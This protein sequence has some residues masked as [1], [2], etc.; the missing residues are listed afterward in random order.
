MVTELARLNIARVAR[1]EPPLR[2]GIGIH[3]GDAVVG[4]IG[5]PRHRLEYTAIGDTVN[6]ASRI[7]GLTKIAGVMLLRVV[8]D[9]CPGRRSVRVA[10]TAADGDQGQ[11]RAH[12][13]LG[14]DGAG[15]CR[16]ESRGLGVAVP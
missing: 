13:G 1:N 15:G 11:E 14:A 12:R 4:D 9:P 5:S 3:T 2:I 10:G 16:G 7:E 6:T 8:D